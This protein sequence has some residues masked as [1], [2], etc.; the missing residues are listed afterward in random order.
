MTLNT[1]DLSEPV[2]N[3]WSVQTLLQ[4]L[5]SWAEEEFIFKLLIKFYSKV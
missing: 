2:F 1:N 4:V 3:S 5:K